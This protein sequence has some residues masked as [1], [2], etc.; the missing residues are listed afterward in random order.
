[1][2]GQKQAQVISI[3]TEILGIPP[4][5]GNFTWLINI[6]QPENFGR[7][8]KDRINIYNKL[9]GDSSIL[10]NLKS[11]RKLSPDA[12]FPPPLGFIFEFDEL[13]HFTSF[14]RIAL[15]NYPQKLSYGFEIEKYIGYCKQYSDAA[16]RKGPGGYRKPTKEFQ[17]N[18]GRAAQRAFFDAFRDIQPTI[19]G[20]NPT[21]RIAEFELPD[22][23]SKSDVELVLV[24]KLHMIGIKI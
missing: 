15:E 20:L 3:I 23:F 4:E 2:P 16:L 5:K 13:Q 8:F 1:M 7:H 19:F 6:P 11:G 12:Y 22:S 9:G 10:K 24:S 18:N 17:F 14:K 21:V